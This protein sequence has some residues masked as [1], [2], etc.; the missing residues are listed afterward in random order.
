MK[1]LL[2]SSGVIYVHLD[3]HAGHYVKVELDR[4]F[5]YENFRNE[6]IWCYSGGGV[7]RKD[8]PRKHDVLLRYSKTDQYEFTV[9]RKAYKENT[10]QVGIHSTYGRDKGQDVSIDLQRG[11]PVTDWWADVP[12]V[13]GWNPEK[14]GYPTQKPEVLLERVIRA[15][16]NHGDV[17]ADFFCGGGTTPTVAQKLG[18]RWIASDISRVA[19]SITADRVAKVVEAQQ[20]KAK[21]AGKQ[22]AVPDFE[23]AHWGIY[24]VAGLS[25]MSQDAFHGF[26]LSAYEARVESTTSAIH[27]YK[28]AEPVNVGSP[29]PDKPVRKEQ[30]AEFANA[31]LQRRGSGGA[32]TMIAWAFT[33][34]ARQMAGRVAAQEKVKLQFVKLRLVPLESP[35]FAAHVT[36][37]HERYGE[38]VAFVL[39]PSIRLR[40]KKLGPRRYAFDAS[41]SVA[42][43]SGAR[44]INAQ[45]DF[46]YL[47]YFTSTPGFEL[48]R[49]KK[50]EPILTAEYEFP[51]S[52]DFELAVRVQ[53]DLGGEAV[54]RESLSVS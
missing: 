34:A 26:V 17:V 35:E 53:D 51:H 1:R 37:K 42:L 48:Q 24:E 4:L 52:G 45:W 33:E 31:V 44:I 25:Q 14:I 15:D 49:T 30:V 21:T 23:V 22:I 13:T 2:A 40:R 11:T 41:E 5:G 27:G 43:N 3:W 39:P 20:A 32:G 47:D 46:D 50:G 12:T 29:D 54:Y 28:G 18:R 8:F 38:L 7:P 9:E 36:G 10:Q 19:V 6:I 16:T